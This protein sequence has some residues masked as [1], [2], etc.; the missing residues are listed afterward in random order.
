MVPDMSALAWYGLVVA[1]LGCVI[2]LVLNRLS[3]PNSFGPRLGTALATAM[4]W[5]LVLPVLAFG[6]VVI[7]RL[8]RTRTATPKPATATR[9]VPAA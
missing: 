6:S 7:A 5:P 1:V 9:A 4:A 8:I 2:L 3:W